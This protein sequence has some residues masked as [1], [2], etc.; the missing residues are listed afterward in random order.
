MRH[1]RRARS[2]WEFCPS[3]P[4]FC[5][6][7]VAIVPF[8]YESAGNGDVSDPIMEDDAIT[9]ITQALGYRPAE[10][11]QFNNYCRSDLDGHLLLARF[12]ASLAAE[13]HGVADI[14]GATLP[15]CFERLAGVH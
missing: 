4:G 13:Y 2:S 8:S 1:M 11:L 9:A 7:S 12:A 6:F 5:Q 15:V 10:S 14:G 3:K